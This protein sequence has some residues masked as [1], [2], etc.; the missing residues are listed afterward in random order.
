MHAQMTCR[1]QWWC[2]RSFRAEW[3]SNW[4]VHTVVALLPPVASVY[5][6]VTACFYYFTLLEFVLPLLLI[7]HL[8]PL[9]CVCRGTLPLKT[10][11]MARRRTSSV[12]CWCWS[13]THASWSSKLK[14]MQ[15]RV[16]LFYCSSFAMHMDRIEL[17]PS[18]H[19]IAGA[20][21][22]CD[23]H[24]RLLWPYVAWSARRQIVVVEDK[25]Q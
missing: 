14:T 15:I 10:P 6:S 13:R 22:P 21:Q 20:R 5:T 4:P 9:F 3:W 24:R 18:L 7:N 11:R 19:T 25:G 17:N 2:L 8:F 12:D 23:Q 1:N 16:S